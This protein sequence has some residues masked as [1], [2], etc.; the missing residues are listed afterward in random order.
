[1]VF[2]EFLSL[3]ESTENAKC[4]RKK[5]KCVATPENSI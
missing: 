5:K 3:E 2:E 4:I 1:M